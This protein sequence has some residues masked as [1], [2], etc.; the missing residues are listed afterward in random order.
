MKRSAFLGCGVLAAAG[1]LWGCSSMPGMGPSWTTLIDGERGL[2]NFDRI[3]EANWR[4]EQG[5]IVAD[6]GAGGYLVSKQTWRDFAVL[7][8]AVL[9]TALSIFVLNIIIDACYALLDARVREPVMA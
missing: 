8:A 3:G 7:Q 6:R 5:A 1:V 9:L 4:P 2:E